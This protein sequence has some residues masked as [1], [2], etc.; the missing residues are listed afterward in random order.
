MKIWIVTLRTAMDDT[1]RGAYLSESEARGRLVE[2]AGEVLAA[3]P[4]PGAPEPVAVALYS[5]EG[6]DVQAVD[7]LE[8][9]DDG[10]QA[11]AIR[12]FCR[13]LGWNGK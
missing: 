4:R 3:E 9:G 10:P 5:A 11:D 6:A 1:I 12:D 7:Q 2:V 13:G 8:F